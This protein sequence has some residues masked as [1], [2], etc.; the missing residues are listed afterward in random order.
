MRHNEMINPKPELRPTPMAICRT[1]DR[2]LDSQ[3]WWTG[4]RP[5]SGLCPGVDQHGK[6]HSL[7]MPD[8]DNC[9]RQEVQDYFDNS[10]TLTEVLLSGLKSEEVFYLIPYHGLRHPLV[11]YYIHQAVLYVNKLRLGGLISRAVNSKFESLFETGV[12]EMSWDDMSKNTMEWPPLHELHQYRK[13]VYKVV[14]RIIASHEGLN[15]GHLP[16]K[17]TDPLWTLFMG[18]EHERIHLETSSVLIRELPLEY[19]KK[20]EAWPDLDMAS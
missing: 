14:S 20:P 11:F 12:D 19:I 6:I 5:L 4:K 7:T 18:F 3:S 10:W 2:L 1:D 9:T 16:I 8:L 13:Q 15:E 17:Q